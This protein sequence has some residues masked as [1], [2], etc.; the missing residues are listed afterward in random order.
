MY[1]KPHVWNLKEQFTQSQQLSPPP[2]WRNAQCCSVSLFND[3][4]S[5]G[6][7]AL[8]KSLKALQ[9]KEPEKSKS[10]VVGGFH[11]LYSDYDESREWFVFKFCY[12]SKLNDINDVSDGEMTNVLKLQR[13]IL[14]L[15]SSNMIFS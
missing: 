11:G 3:W 1:N 7:P 2:R 10:G 4:S 15:V 13:L 6:R 12:I 14:V 9:V 8:S 5:W